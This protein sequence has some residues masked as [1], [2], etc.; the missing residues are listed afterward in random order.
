M[1]IDL[2]NKANMKENVAGDD[3]ISQGV[4]TSRRWR[5]QERLATCSK[6]VEKQFDEDESSGFLAAARM[7]VHDDEEAEAI[8]LKN[9]ESSSS[10]SRSER[11][12]AIHNQDACTRHSYD[13]KRRKRG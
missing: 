4:E 13:F 3:A 1:F 10:M 7:K 11:A 6:P 2:G 5:G 9:I 12:D 8:L